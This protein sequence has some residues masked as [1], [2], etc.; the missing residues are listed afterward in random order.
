MQESEYILYKII[1]EIFLKILPVFYP[2]LKINS[3]DSVLIKS[4][5][6]SPYTCLVIQ[7]N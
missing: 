5:P 3:C 7:F 1:N 4:Y 2:N 6:V